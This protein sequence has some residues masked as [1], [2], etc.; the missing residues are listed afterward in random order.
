MSGSRRQPARE[1]RS[2]F[3]PRGDLIFCRELCRSE[4]PAER[5]ITARVGSSL[6]SDWRGWCDRSGASALLTL[7]FLPKSA[8][9]CNPIGSIRSAETGEMFGPAIEALA[10]FSHKLR[11]QGHDE[12]FRTTTRSYSPT[13]K[14]GLSNKRTQKISKGSRKSVPIV[15]LLLLI[16][17]QRLQRFLVLLSATSA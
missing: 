8:N 14:S 13:G 17:K 3:M 9:P 15:R 7:C 6:A 5:G 10:R 16:E 1:G 12:R 11:D 4:A 2:G